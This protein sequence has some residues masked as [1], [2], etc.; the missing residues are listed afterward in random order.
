MQVHNLGE[1]VNCTSTVPRHTV[2]DLSMTV[3]FLFLFY[4][5]Q[6]S[7]FY[8]YT[9]ATRRSS[10]PPV[11]SVALTP[12]RSCAFRTRMRFFDTRL[13]QIFSM[14]FVDCGVSAPNPPDPT[15]IGGVGNIPLSFV[16]IV[17]CLWFRRA[18]PYSRVR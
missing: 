14:H 15:R 11:G 2:G 5:C 9:V 13:D 17:P 18:R 3:F 10:C 6:I 16:T 4:L 1:S 12:I 8:V 7:A